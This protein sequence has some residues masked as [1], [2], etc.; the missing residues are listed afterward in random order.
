M[1]E[2]LHVIRP[3]PLRKGSKLSLSIS[4]R[5]ASCFWSTHPAPVLHDDSLAS[6]PSLTAHLDQELHPR[7]EDKQS[8]KLSSPGAVREAVHTS[9]LSAEEVLRV[10]GS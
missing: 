6:I 10:A 8:I 5:F 1:Q 4:G 9:Q 7:I 2:H 3:L